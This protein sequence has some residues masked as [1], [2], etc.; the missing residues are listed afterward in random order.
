MPRLTGLGHQ[1]LLTTLGPSRPQVLEVVDHIEAGGVLPPVVVLQT[2]SRNSTITMG[3]VRGYVARQ[4]RG[5]EAGSCKFVEG[6]I[7]HEDCC[8]DGRAI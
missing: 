4:V 5:D 6:N 1:E 8:R 2:L 3:H 7:C